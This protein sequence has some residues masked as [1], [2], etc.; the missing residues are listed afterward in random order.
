M[1]SALG[2]ALVRILLRIPISIELIPVPGM[3]PDPG[4]QA[5]ADLPSQAA[6][7]RARFGHAD[8]RQRQE[9]HAAHEHAAD[10]PIA[11]VAG[12]ENRAAAL[13]E[14]L[15]ESLPILRRRLEQR[16]RALV[17]ERQRSYKID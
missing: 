11:V 14:Q 6:H 2:E 5:I 17:V 13:G 4:A 8:D 16:R 9:Q 15:V 12:D 7:L 10:L 3:P 1:A